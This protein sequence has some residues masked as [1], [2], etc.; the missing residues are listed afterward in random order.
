MDTTYKIINQGGLILN[1]NLAYYAEQIQSTE[2]ITDITISSGSFSE[3]IDLTS[4][5]MQTIKIT[6]PYEDLPKSIDPQTLSIDIENPN[7]GNIV[8]ELEYLTQNDNT[9]LLNGSILDLSQGGWVVLNFGI[10]HPYET[11]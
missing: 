8:E 6:I 3:H 11:V 7:D 1:I 4:P 10:D 2:G 5:S 9:I